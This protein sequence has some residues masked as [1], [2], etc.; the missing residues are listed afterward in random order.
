MAASNI[1]ETKHG[2]PTSE[3]VCG[4]SCGLSKSLP[5]ALPY[6]WTTC[7]Q[8]IL[9]A[10]VEKFTFAQAEHFS[11]LYPACERAKVKVIVES[12][13]AAL[14]RSGLPC[15]A[16]LHGRAGLIPYLP[17]QTQKTSQI[18]SLPSIYGHE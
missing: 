2:P 3:T 1:M 17:F 9:F 8:S 15:D 13:G 7:R 4:Q 18:H 11:S 12:G 16:L 5:A 6:L 10:D 14:R